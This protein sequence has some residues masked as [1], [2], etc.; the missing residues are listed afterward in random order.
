MEQV[1]AEI[2]LNY[3]TVKV[4][5]G[6]ID[7]GLLAVPVSL[8]GLFPKQKGWIFIDNTDGVY[9]KKAYTPYASSSRECRIGGL[10]DFYSK[11]AFKNND[12][13][14]IQKINDDTFR[15]LPEKV[16]RKN[17]ADSL[18]KFENSTN[19]VD[20]DRYLKE[21][22][23]ISNLDKKTILCNEFVQ[24][25]KRKISSRIIERKTLSPSKES[26]PL[27]MRKILRSMYDGKCQI[28]NFAFLM[29]NGDPY[30]EIHHID[31]L[32]GNHPKNLLVV[33]PN[34]HT[35]FTYSH[36]EQSFDNNGWL[37]S[38]KFNGEFFNVFQII[39]TLKLKFTKEVY[40]T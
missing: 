37:R 13:L 16:F 22:S 5:Q 2:P 24:L 1:I 28:T 14:V 6:R 7:K 39:D 38:V 25:S 26:V 21:V 27:S 9:E 23:E 8:I 12:E 11:Y 17:I 19:E 31:P 36:I 15:L 30:F 3:I 4:T 40:F 32:I 35:Q 33:C 20:A 34:V 29:K 18:S 10:K